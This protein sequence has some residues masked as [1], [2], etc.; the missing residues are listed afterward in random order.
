MPGRFQPGDHLRVRRRGLYDHHGIYISDDRVI[1]FGSGISLW[2]KSRTSV[3]AVSL[4]QFEQDETA[5]LVR[6]GY[7]SLF[8]T[9]Y[10]PPADEPWKIVE[11]AEFMLKLQPK[12]P[13]N[14][15]GHNCEHVANLCVSRFWGRELSDPQVV[16]PEGHGGHRAAL[17]A[18]CALTKRPVASALGDARDRGMGCWRRCGNLDVQPSDQAVLGRD[19]SAMARPRSRA[20]RGPAQRR[21]LNNR[22]TAQQQRP[23]PTANASSTATHHPTRPERIAT[24][25]SARLR[26]PYRHWP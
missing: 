9:G 6:H 15:I 23:A 16:R 8:D 20:G 21:G 19:R 17:V 14:L 13:Y 10:H 24:R 25:R 2:D 12:L 4:E 18:S 5:Q 7:E 26:P 22:P 3:N 1:Q 11:R